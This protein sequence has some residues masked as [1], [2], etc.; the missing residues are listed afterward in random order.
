[1]DEYRTWTRPTDDGRRLWAGR[2]FFTLA[3]HRTW[4]TLCRIEAM[5]AGAGYGSAA[6]RWLCKVADKHGVKLSGI[7]EPFGSRF[8]ELE[9]L[10]AWYVVFGFEVTV[11]DFYYIDREPRRK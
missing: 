9:K 3:P 6:L 11:K 10:M 8:L 5:H 4:I 7:A 2:V 1:M